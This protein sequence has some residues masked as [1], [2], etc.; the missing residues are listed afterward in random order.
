M[1]NVLYNNVKKYRLEMGYVLDMREPDMIALSCNTCMQ[2]II[3]NKYFFYN[4]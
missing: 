1:H 4:T 2:V 3:Y